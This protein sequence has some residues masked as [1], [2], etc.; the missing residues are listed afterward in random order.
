MGSSHNQAFI[1]VLK[2]FILSLLNLLPKHCASQSVPTVI[3]PYNEL[4]F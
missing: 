4:F 1:F 3:K 2:K